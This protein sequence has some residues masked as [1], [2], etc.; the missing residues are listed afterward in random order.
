MAERSVSF[1]QCVQ[2]GAKSAVV[3]PEDS[4]L[5]ALRA[6]GELTAEERTIGGVCHIAHPGGDGLTLSMHKPLDRNFLAHVDWSSGTLKEGEGGDGRDSDYANST[7]VHFYPRFGAFAMAA[8]N[9][10]SPR[11][12]AVKR[13]MERCFPLEHGFHWAVRPI[14]DTTAL[15]V[16]KGSTIGITSLTT[17]FSTLKQLGLEPT[18]VASFGDA[19]AENIDAE[20]DIDVTMTLNAKRGASR[21]MQKRLRGALLRDLARLL[22]GKD[23]GTKVT[24]ILE[25]GRTEILDLVEQALV[26]SQEIDDKDTASNE[27]LFRELL[28]IIVSVSDD[29]QDQVYGMLER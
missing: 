6:F 22:A 27:R 13:L 5:N 26:V 21:G 29:R 17:K 14:M 8:V 16:F 10:A 23:N 18:G 4:Y 1:W 25:N 19:L 12:G 24:A 20:L 2:E 15:D 3:W 7:A 9:R 28:N 11:Q